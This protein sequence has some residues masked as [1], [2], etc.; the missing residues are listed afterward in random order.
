MV[1]EIKT[2]K[3]LEEEWGP[4]NALS[5]LEIKNMLSW[6]KLKST[7]IFYDLGSGHGRVIRLAVQHAHVKK[8]IGIEHVEDRFCRSREIVKRTISKSDLKKVDFL[9]GDMEDFDLSDATV[10]Y[11]GHDPY[12]KEDQMYRKL[13]GGKK[14]KI[15]KRHL[16][17]IGYK[18][19]GAFR[20][21]NRSWFFVMQTPLKKHRTYS[22]NEWFSS[23]LGKGGV[24][25][26]EFLND[27][28]KRLKKFIEV[29]E[30]RESI[31]HIKKLI[32]KFLPRT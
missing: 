13:F 5:P 32:Q 30:R 12:D 18:H 10:V 2:E 28:D 24:Q 9:F 15:I 31:R 4:A 7:D 23:V 11:E 25:M 21:K 27:Y 17:L 1:M 3:Q 29:K 14:V 19:V 6:V 16:P 22:K 20:S 8:A 26:D